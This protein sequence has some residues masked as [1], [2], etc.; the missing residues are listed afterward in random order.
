M[1]FMVSSASP[2]GVLDRA[3]DAEDALHK[4]FLRLVGYSHM[5]QSQLPMIRKY[6]QRRIY[7][8]CFVSINM[9]LLESVQG[10]TC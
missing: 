9:R 1:V 7:V 4:D 10:K 3:I 8:E 5:L 2:G 6:S